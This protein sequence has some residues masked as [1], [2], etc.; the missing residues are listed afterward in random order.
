MTT[1][2]TVTD[3]DKGWKRI[4]RDLA[5]MNGM[6][7]AVGYLESTDAREDGKATN[8]QIGAANEF[9]VPSKGIPE[10]SHIRST[11]DE[12]AR[13]YR[14]LGKHLTGMVTDGDLSPKHAHEILGMRVVADIKRTIQHGVPPP[15]K[16]ATIKAK[17]SSKTLIAS[18]QMDNAITSEV[19]T[20]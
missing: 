15:N 19:R 20:K 10:R 7:T 6:A 12:N 2:T 11:I 8:A 16:P 9:G 5:E 17:G 1:L 14:Q 18:G 13:E 4:Q 3:T